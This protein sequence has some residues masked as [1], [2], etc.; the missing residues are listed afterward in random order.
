MCLR[1]LILDNDVHTLKL[2][3]E[4]NRVDKE[5]IYYAFQTAVG[6]GKLEATRLLMGDPRVDLADND[7]ETLVNAASSGYT[8]IV[9]EMLARPEVD[10]NAREAAP[11]FTARYRHVVP[12]N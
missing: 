11:A 10:P 6:S 1:R 8:N 5:R 7:N 4:H 12:D 2:L 3:M 9:R